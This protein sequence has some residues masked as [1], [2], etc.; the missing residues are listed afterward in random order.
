MNT[1]RR[2]SKGASTRNV[3]T[4]Y[5]TFGVRTPVEGLPHTETSPEMV[6]KATFIGNLHQVFK[7]AAGEEQEKL[8]IG[9]LLERECMTCIDTE[10]NRLGRELQNGHKRKRRKKD[11]KTHRGLWPGLTSQFSVLIRLAIRERLASVSWIIPATL[12]GNFWQ[13]CWRVCPPF[14]GRLACQRDAPP[15]HTHTHTHTQGY[16]RVV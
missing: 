2:R 4:T 1:I 9:Y 5:F 14:N 8:R 6:K 12:A 16:Q 11:K 10:V 15:T 13:P 3:R 7:G